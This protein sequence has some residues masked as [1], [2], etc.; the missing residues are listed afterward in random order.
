LKPS[1]D[2]NDFRIDELPANAD[3]QPVLV[4]LEVVSFLSGQ[5]LVRTTSNDK[6]QTIQNS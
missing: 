2:S 1:D 6:K 5:I 3:K 4:W